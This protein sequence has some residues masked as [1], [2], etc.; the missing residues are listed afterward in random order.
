MAGFKNYYLSISEI[1]KSIGVSDNTV[2]KWIHKHEIPVHRIS[3]LS[4]FKKE[5]VEKW[6]KIGG[7]EEHYKKES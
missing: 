5:K 3:L 6:A 2:N 4:K 7:V 1:C